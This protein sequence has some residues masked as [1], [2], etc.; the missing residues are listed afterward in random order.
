MD[1]GVIRISEIAP[2]CA[3]V[4][5]QAEHVKLHADK[6]SAYARFIAGKYPVT[7]QLGGDK[8]FISGD[9]GLTAAYVLALDSINFGSG[10]FSIAQECGIALEYEVIARGLKKHFEQGRDWK[11]LSA[12][13]FS[14]MFSMPLG[15]HPKLDELLHNFEMH[16]RETAERVEKPIDLLQGSAVK[17]AETVAAWP[18]FHDVHP[19]KGRD[20]PIL[21][22]AQ[23]LAADMN[24]ALGGLADVDKLTIFADNM[25]PHVLRC[26]GIL[27]YSSDEVIPSGSEKEV[28]IR[29]LAIHA[30]ELMKRET[31]LTAV[32]LDHMLWHRGYE[33]EI[34]NRKPHRTL[35]VWY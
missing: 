17:L 34:Y 35:S 4:A 23:I 14:A 18:G 26:D 10:Y 20:I 32:N 30:V 6:I 1:S 8:H 15:V 11:N 28:E 33:P 29:S 24:L 27:E 12:A 31:S 2:A 13:D 22:R 7:T 5:G 9:R 25:V 21:K 19:Y 3:W 16:L